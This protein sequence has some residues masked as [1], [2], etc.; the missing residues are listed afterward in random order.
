[1]TCAGGDWRMQLQPDGH[2]SPTVQQIPTLEGF[3]P[4]AGV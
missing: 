1:M 3:I 4:W 2:R